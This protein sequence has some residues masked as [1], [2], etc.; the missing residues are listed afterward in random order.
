MKHHY[1]KLESIKFDARREPFRDY[2][3]WVDKQDIPLGELLEHC[4]AYMGHMSL[5]RL[6]TLFEMYKSVQG[7]AG[8]I[9]EVGVYKGAGSIL[10]QNWYKSSKL[11]H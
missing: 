2:L 9:A 1:G 11:S 10:L 5:N 6:L 7:V 3:N 8:H 4:S